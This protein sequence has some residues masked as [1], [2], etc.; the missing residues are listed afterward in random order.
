MKRDRRRGRAFLLAPAS[1][2]LL[3][4]G[5]VAQDVGYEGPSYTGSSLE[6]VALVTRPTATPRWRSRW[7]PSMPT[8]PG[9]K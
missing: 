3:A 9:T 5:L 6:P 8:L 1:L 7:M 4:S 2:A